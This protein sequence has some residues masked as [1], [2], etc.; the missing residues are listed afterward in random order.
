MFNFIK[1][2]YELGKVSKQWVLAQVPKWITQ[3]Q[4][5]LILGGNLYEAAV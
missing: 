5:E 4:A 1:F 2:Q 3:Q